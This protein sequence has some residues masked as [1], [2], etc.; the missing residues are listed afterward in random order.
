MKRLLRFAFPFLVLGGLG[1]DNLYASGRIAS[2][3]TACGDGAAYCVVDL[4]GGCGAAQYP[5][6]YLD[7]VPAGG[8]GEEYKTTKLV[9]RRIESGTFVMGSPTTERG[10]HEGEV[11]HRVTLSKG[12]YMGV[13]EITQRQW[14]LVTGAR[15]S[16]F[17]AAQYYATRPVECVSYTT[18]RGWPSGD[19]WPETREPVADSFVGVLQ[20]KTGL[21]FDLPTEA[22]WE[23]ACRAGTTTALNSGE[24]LSDLNYP[25]RYLNVLARYTPNR[26]SGDLQPTV[27]EPS[28]GTATV[29]SY[30]PNAWGLYDM[31]GNVS[32]W[33]LDWEG[34]YSGD[35][36]D[37]MGGVTSAGTGFRMYRGGGWNDE[38]QY[39]RSAWRNGVVPGHQS[40]SLG[41]RLVRNLDVV[42][43][44][45]ACG[46]TPEVP[47]VK[48]PTFGTPGAL[49]RATRTGY[50]LVGWYTEPNGGGSLVRE[51]TQVARDMTLY[52]LWLPQ[53]Y[54][55]IDLSA[56]ADA[57]CYPVTYLDDVP[58]GGWTDA[59]KTTKLVLSRLPAGT[60]L[61]GSPEN[62]RG[63]YSWEIRHKV[64]LTKPFYMGVFEVT[65]RQWELVKGTRP[66]YFCNANFYAVR[67]VESVSYS[68]IRGGGLESTWPETREVGAG[69]FLGL[70]RRKTGLALDLP[71]EAQWEYACRAGT[72]NA[73]NSGKE[74]AEDYYACP[75]L[76][77]LARYTPSWPTPV[78]PSAT[79]TLSGGTTVVGLYRPNAWGI[80]DMHG[81]VSEWCLD[82]YG[83][84][85]GDAVDPR[86]VETRD[87]ELTRVC[88]GGGWSSR[89]E[90]CRS[91]CRD[92]CRYDSAGSTIGFRLA[93]IPDETSGGGDE[94][95]AEE[96]QADEDGKE[97]E[98]KSEQLSDFC[99]WL[100]DRGRLESVGVPAD[101]KAL[102]SVSVPAKGSTLLDEF[103][104]G[105]DPE[106]E[107]SKFEARIEMK[108]G[109]PEVIWE[110]AL[111]GN[112]V[113]EGVRTYRVLGTRALGGTWEEV[114]EGRESDYQ[115][116]RVTVELP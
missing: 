26:T 103:I 4:S 39:C 74:L 53:K 3:A 44:L 56:G 114:P 43:T 84:Y 11:Q 55:V 59:H 86:G 50:G 21:A 95:P 65:Q 47:V 17:S 64:T 107:E 82:W 69:S 105:T 22:Q 54:C 51:N 76:N 81:N 52:A 66:S 97:P 20:R 106:K 29:G 108:D 98:L 34:A 42:L 9:L 102:R 57:G 1:L 94:P 112:G 48:V 5:V 45:D 49:P 7:D 92:T 30:L 111:N 91:A 32:E 77:Q 101:A 104:A 13:F 8:W 83:N 79:A 61:M 63:H 99:Q 116:F 71:T 90:Y 2:P 38:A 88:R 40:N 113:K 115:F 19:W 58:Q 87:C 96:P 24:N 85:A 46:G 14:E 67:P 35:A 75:N 6:S 28:A 16:N 110:P 89:A 62:E 41:L 70:I 15:P 37:P 25:C 93:L 72:T 109:K 36:V 73:L 80:Y 23:Y 27:P 33:C 78:T 18:I 68:S 100:K 31:H 60:F 12:Y 10:R